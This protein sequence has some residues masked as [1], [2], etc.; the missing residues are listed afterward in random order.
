MKITISQIRE[1]VH[2]CLAEA[3]SEKQRKWACAQAGSARKNYKG[4][5][6]LTKKQAKEFCADTKL[7]GKK[8]KKK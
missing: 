2:E 3:A 4:K 6:S 5:P 8:K 1:I 7:S